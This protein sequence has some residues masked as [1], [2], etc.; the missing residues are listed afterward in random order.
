MQKSKKVKKIAETFR[1]AL[2]FEPVRSKS[3]SE[4]LFGSDSF[5]ALF[6]ERFGI[7]AEN[8]EAFNA[9]FRDVTEGGGNEITKINS[10]NSSALLQLLVFYKLYSRKVGQHLSM[11]IKGE[12]IY[13]DK[14]FFEV[15]NNVIGRPSCVDVALV[16][17]DGGTILF[18]E[19][20]LTEMFEG[21][22]LEN[23]YGKSYKSLYWRTA[24]EEALK[25][26]G[27]KVDADATNLI[28]SSEDN[29]QYLEGIKQTISHLIGLVRGPQGTDDQRE[30]QEAYENAKRLIYSP[31][32]Y[33]TRTILNED[34]DES[35][36]FAVLYNT[37][38]GK[39][40]T[41]ILETIKIWVMRKGYKCEGSNKKIEIC[42]SVLTYQNIM[43]ENPSW[44]DE[45]VKT[46]YG[47]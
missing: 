20:K 46:Y 43:K 26:G 8:K 38:I 44:L 32:L 41:H 24:I 16:S 34:Y 21:S 4:L 42:P 33:D 12:T 27:I 45:K 40:C 37:V 6:I 28:L 3:G 10:V 5:A 47:L 11:T 7:T 23:E 30:Y 1:N 36:K 35:S 17:N 29:L 19:S 18:L 25:D 2:G 13:F 31:I 9:A 39:N 22:T 14:A 15:R